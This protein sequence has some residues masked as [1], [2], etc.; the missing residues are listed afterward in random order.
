[1]EPEE[2]SLSAHEREVFAALEAS[3]SD[4]TTNANTHITRRRR[5]STQL[6]VATVVS[7]VATVGLLS[8]SYLAAFLAFVALT[9]SV[10]FGWRLWSL[11]VLTK[12]NAFLAE[13]GH[14]AFQHDGLKRR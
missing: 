12:A 5:R 9:L 13:R 10:H 1:M 14:H 4:L 11:H 6:A 7:A 3:L 8:V 2:S